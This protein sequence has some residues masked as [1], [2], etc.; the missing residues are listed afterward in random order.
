MTVRDA[1]FSRTSRPEDRN[2]HTRPQQARR[3]TWKHTEN[4]SPHMRARR[5]AHEHPHEHAC[6]HGWAYTRS[7]THARAGMHACAHTCTPWLAGAAGPGAVQLGGPLLTFCLSDVQSEEPSAER[8]RGEA[9]H[10]EGLTQ[11]RPRPRPEQ[12][13]SYRRGPKRCRTARLGAGS[14]TSVSVANQTRD[15]T[16]KQSSPRHALL[17]QTP[18]Q[19]QC[20]TLESS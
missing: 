19:A 17:R 12:S 16:G 11:R 3:G 1:Y 20:V 2:E 4:H 10:R 5:H 14:S 9:G 7:L 8:R 6:V 18:Q 15:T 13:T